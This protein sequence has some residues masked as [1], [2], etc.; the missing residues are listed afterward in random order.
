MLYEV[1]EY[2]AV[3]GRLP[4]LVARFNDHTFRLF[5]R[6]GMEVVD[7]GLTTIGDNSFNEIV[8]TMRFD[9][10]ADMERKW[11][12]FTSDPEWVAVFAETEAEGP[13]IQSMRRRVLDA[14]AF[15]GAPE[16]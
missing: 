7:I 1:R 16:R 11:A 4:A 13:L 2:V 8:Y 14:G 3:P 15:S 5:A 12:Q 9:D 10:L 6:Y